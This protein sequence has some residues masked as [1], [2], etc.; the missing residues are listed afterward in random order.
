MKIDYDNPIL[1]CVDKIFNGVTDDGI[2]FDIQTYYTEEDG[3]QVEKITFTN[4]TPNQKLLKQQITNTFLE[5]IG[6]ATG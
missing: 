4:K 2:E 3:W 6:L 1:I 5:N